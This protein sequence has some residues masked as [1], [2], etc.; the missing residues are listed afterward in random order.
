MKVRITKYDPRLRTADDRF[1]ADDWTSVSDIGRFPGLTVEEYLKTEDNYWRTLASIL[2]FLGVSR[3]TVQQIGFS[4]RP[5]DNA[6]SEESR[7]FCSALTLGELSSC[8]MQT[9]EKLFKA[10]LREEIGFQAYT[11]DDD[12]D[13]DP[14]TGEGYFY[15]GCGYDFYL[16]AESYAD[17]KWIDIP[18]IFVEEIPH[19]PNYR[20]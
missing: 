8:G 14:E 16:Y 18:G 4:N 11:D 1:M 5:T 12:Y 17:F 2:S 6:L 19:I 9:L 20:D 15:A 7:E 13:R 3:V 10:A